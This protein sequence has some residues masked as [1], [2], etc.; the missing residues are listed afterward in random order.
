MLGAE[1]LWRKRW[2]GSSKAEMVS[3]EQMPDLDTLRRNW[4]AEQRELSAF[5][6]PPSDDDLIKSGGYLSSR[7]AQWSEPLWQLMFQLVNHGT[8]HRSEVAMALTQV[9]HS[10]GY[11]DYIAFVRE[12]RTQRAQS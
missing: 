6:D 2:T 8:Q 1:A 9:D 4:N 7:G 5:V 12:R 3:E 11:L 10:P